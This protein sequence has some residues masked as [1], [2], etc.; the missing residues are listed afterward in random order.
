[1]RLKYHVGLVESLKPF[2]RVEVAEK[3]VIPSNSKMWVKV[4]V[5]KPN[6]LSENGYIEAESETFSNQRLA[7]VRGIVKT[8]QPEQNIQV[9]N[10]G[11]TTDVT[12]YENMKIGTCESVYDDST[13]PKVN[14]CARIDVVDRPS[15]LEELPDHLIDLKERS[16][17]H[18]NDCE[19]E[20]LTALLTKCQKV[21]AESSSDLGKTDRVQHRIHTGTAQPLR[22]APRRLPL[23]K[24]EI[25]IEKQEVQKM[26]DRGV[27]EPSTWKKTYKR[28]CLVNEIRV[29]SVLDIRKRPD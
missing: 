8:S 13:T 3:T 20:A 26:L 7:I 16:S 29:K 15:S 4:T 14:R 23:G 1:M 24:K 27:I 12:L 10:F 19:T 9:V 5:P 21:F 28:R 17:I 11:Q 2:C 25:E 22:Q 6:H 18:L